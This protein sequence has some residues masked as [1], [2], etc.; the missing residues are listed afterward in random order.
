V[1]GVNIMPVAGKNAVPI[2]DDDGTKS[3]EPVP[4]NDEFVVWIILLS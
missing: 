3:H 2:N 1:G 4:G